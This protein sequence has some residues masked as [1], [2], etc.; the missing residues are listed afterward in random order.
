MDFFRGGKYL[1]LGYGHGIYRKNFFHSHLLENSP[2]DKSAAG[3]VAV[4]P[5][6]HKTLESAQALLVPLL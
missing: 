4:L 6:N 5:G 2:D 1:H 3:L